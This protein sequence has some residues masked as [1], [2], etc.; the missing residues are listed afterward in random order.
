MIEK[1][2]SN[3]LAHDAK[4]NALDYIK[5]LK[6]VFISNPLQCYFLLIGILIQGTLSSATIWLS[7]K[8][9][10]EISKLQHYDRSVM[11]Y[12]CIAWC[13]SLLIS[14]F[15]EPW[16]LYWQS[17]VSDNAV[18]NINKNIIEKSNS[19]KR[20]D[21]FEKEEFYNDIQ[22]LQS[23]ASNKPINLVVT[24]V[25]LARDIVII[26]TLLL[27]LY[28]IVP[29]V[30]LVVL[31][32]AY[33]NY[34]TFS[35]LQEKTWQESLGRSVDSR[36]MNYLSMTSINARFAKEIRLF[37]LGSYLVDEYVKGFKNIHTRMKKVRLKQALWPILPILLTAAGNLLAFVVIVNSAMTGA[38]SVGAVIL[39]LQALS[40]LHLTVTNFGEQAGWLKGHILFFSKYFN[41]IKLK[42]VTNSDHGSI[43]FGNLENVTIEF[44]NV[45][46]AILKDINFIINKGEK[47]AI[48]GENGA[49]KSTLIKLLCGF[50]TPTSGEILI[51]GKSLNSINLDNW[52]DQISPLFQDYNSYSFPLHRN[53]IMGKTLVQDDLNKA[54]LNSGVSNFASLLPNEM[55]ALLGKDFGG[56]ELSIGEWQKVALA[57]ALYKNAPLY[58]MDEPTS[59]MDPL[60]ERTIFTKF[61]AGAK[62]KTVIFV[63]HKLSLSLLADKI[64]LFH[65]GK[66]VGQGCHKDLLVTSKLYA[67][68]FK[69]QADIYLNFDL[70][71]EMFESF[72]NS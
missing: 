27:L 70:D 35:V 64:I 36:K 13:L 60:S 14:N 41:F 56:A 55:N 52:R 45:S 40:Q 28:S 49:G 22:V 46:F 1:I 9:I 24:T 29:W 44:K 32:S 10:T 67:E 2:K 5:A 37:N 6:L 39:F 26:T 43:S 33:I 58:F 54:S 11:I 23:Q 48:I 71:K 61:I 31:I 65:Q 34:K 59:S 8:V 72:S 51:N 18:H 16:I 30:S 50:Y 21:F 47:I 20:L 12:L 66:V 53:I 57:R 3:L 17:N 38:T 19:I 68:M 7:S 25:G 63:T 69:S 15:I 42:E 62:D 4:K